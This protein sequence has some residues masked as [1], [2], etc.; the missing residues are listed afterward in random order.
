MALEDYT[1]LEL[2]RSGRGFEPELLIIMLMFMRLCLSCTALILSF[3]L[4]LTLLQ[5]LISL[6][7]NTFFLFRH[8][9]IALASVVFLAFRFFLKI[10]SPL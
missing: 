2:D 10:Y 1:S 9:A 8:V 3:T 7:L 5:F 6:F 4:T